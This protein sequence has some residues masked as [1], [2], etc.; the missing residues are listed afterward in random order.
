[1]RDVYL[2]C[3]FEAG[4]FIVNA[5]GALEDLNNSAKA[6]HFQY[7]ATSNGPVPKLQIHNLCIFGFLQE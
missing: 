2:S 4:P 7:L 5:R 3:E 1:M 6:I